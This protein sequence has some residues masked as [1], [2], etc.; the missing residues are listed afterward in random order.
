MTSTTPNAVDVVT[1]FVTYAR[2]Q[3]D[4]PA[5]SFGAKQVTYR[6]LDRWSAAVARDLAAAG[7]RPGDPVAIFSPDRLETVVA[8]LAILRAG[9]WY[10]VVDPHQ[11]AHRRDLLLR[12]TRSRTVLVSDSV[13]GQLPGNLTVVPLDR[14]EAE[15]W[16]REPDHRLPAYAC[17][18]SGTTGVPKGVQ[19]S[20]DSL[21][22]FCEVIT[23]RLGMRAG[24]RVAGFC[25]TDWD[26]VVVDLWMPLTAGGCA[27]SLEAADRA[28]PEL[29]ARL[30]AETGVELAMLPTALGELVLDTPQIAKADQ[31]K[32]FVVGGDRLMR[33]VPQGAAFSLWNIYGP[34]ETTVV[35]TA[36]EVEPT[37]PL[38]L[39]PIGHPF[40]AGTISIVDEFLRPVPDGT[41]GE[42]LIGGPQVAFGY[43]GE[44]RTT[45]DAFRPAPDG[46]RWYRTGD[47]GRFLPDGQI[48]F[49]GRGDSQVSVNGRRIEMDGVLTLLRSLPAVADAAVG[50]TGT[51]R[52]MV[53][54]AAIVVR[55]PDTTV[56]EIRA[57]LSDWLAPHQ[58]PDRIVMVDAIPRDD[59]GQLA[60]DRLVAAPDAPAE[61]TADADEELDRVEEDELDEWVLDLWA[62]VLGRPAADR[63]ENFFQAGGNSLAAVQFV[64]QLQSAFDVSLPVLRFFD[65]PTPARLAGLLRAA[66]REQLAQMSDEQ[67]AQLLTEPS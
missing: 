34:T 40:R 67:V 16:M 64:Q 24:W 22:Y 63:T 28:N 39:I 1:R 37:G 53:L 62:E 21:S 20:R 18:T 13:A 35:V 54:L 12:R 58:M 41:V 43:L 59:A 51:G 45:A 8:E 27:V 56:A 5:L 66:L 44:P 60:V 30:V 11:S 7:V 14:R 65:R 4:Q 52:A 36:G 17:F 31:L 48:E 23:N 6:E 57:G 26:G 46:G 25:P 2:Q 61:Q 32:V 55:D 49:L 19:V 15:P 38:D 50:L 33:R 10:V 42:I 29:I 3:P 9:G 47:R